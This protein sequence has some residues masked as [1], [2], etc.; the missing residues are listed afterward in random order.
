MK[1]AKNY[2]DKEEKKIKSMIAKTLKNMTLEEIIL[3][4]KNCKDAEWVNKLD[5]NTDGRYV[6]HHVLSWAFVWIDTPEGHDYWQQI[7]YRN[8]VKNSI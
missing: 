5:I 2:T 1:N 3:F 7:A 6:Q 4:F 8:I